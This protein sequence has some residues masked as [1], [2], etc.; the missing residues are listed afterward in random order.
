MPNELIVVPSIY[1]A[2]YAWVDNQTYQTYMTAQ[3]GYPAGGNNRLYRHLTAN[4]A[5]GQTGLQMSTALRAEVSATVTAFLVQ[6]AQ[7]HLN[8]AAPQTAI[9]NVLTRARWAGAD[10]LNQRT[11]Q[12]TTQYLNSG[13]H[14]TQIEGTITTW[15]ATMKRNLVEYWLDQ[16]VAP[17]HAAP[18]VAAVNDAGIANAAGVA[19]AVHY[20]DN[21]NAWQQLG[22]Q[23]NAVPHAAGAN[24]AEMQWFQAHGGAL[25]GLVG[26]VRRVDFHI[27]EQPCA[28][29]CASRVIQNW[30]ALATATPAYIK[31]YADTDGRANLYRLLDDAILRLT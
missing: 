18:A 31:T 7:N 6:Y 5:G 2:S 16:N 13:Q 11:A 14:R 12:Q 15:A 22:N 3:G 9:R 8:F 10:I 29:Y 20:Y 24:H 23:Y 25:A 19:C 26:N 27:S 21:N 1:A 4:I 28:G 17:L 30:A